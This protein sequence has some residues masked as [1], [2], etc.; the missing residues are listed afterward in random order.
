MTA[1]SKT[2]A[3][4]TGTTKA[5]LADL[6][7]LEKASK[8]V[9][10]QMAKDVKKGVEIS[11]EL[12]EQKKKI[13]KAFAAQKSQ[14]K[15]VETATYRQAAMEKM[16][17]SRDGRPGALQKSIQGV[18]MLHHLE[19]EVKRLDASFH[20][21]RAGGPDVD[22]EQ[23]VLDLLHLGSHI[24]GPVGIAMRGASMILQAV[25]AIQASIK[26]E[27]RGIREIGIALNGGRPYQDPDEV[28]RRES[29]QIEKK[30]T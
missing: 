15:A 11:K 6:K 26:N 17:A 14:I 3:M 4:P 27:A 2:I 29:K 9:T 10:R 8:D 23:G 24:P 16:E 1:P 21:F 7:A 30:L 19:I 5:M 28:A 13:D 12:L 25:M 22:K 20:A 18:M